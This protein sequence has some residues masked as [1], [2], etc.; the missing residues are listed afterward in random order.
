MRPKE[1]TV[2]V[3]R[4]FRN[5]GGRRYAS[6]ETDQPLALN[7]ATAKAPLEREGP[8]TLIGKNREQ[9]SK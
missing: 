3:G 8:D 2:T 6:D 7:Q 1:G 9:L 4:R 5:R